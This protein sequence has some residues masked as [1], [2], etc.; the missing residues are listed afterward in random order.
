MV[1][2]IKPDEIKTAEEGK[3]IITKEAFRNMLTHVLR[4][5]NEALESSAEVMGICM[6]KANKKDLIIVNAIPITHGSKVEVGFS[7]EDYIAFAQIDEQYASKGLFAV[8]WYH[9]HPGWGLFYSD[10]DIR[11][12]I[13]YQKD[14]TPYAFGIV[15]D[16]TLMGKD[17]GLGFDVYRLEDYKKGPQSNYV[18]VQY[19]LEIPSTLDYFKWVQ[20]FI[21]DSQ[22]KDPI[23]IKEL[24]EL[25]EPTKDNLQAIPIPDGV[26]PDAVDDY[27]AITPI[28]S[29]FQE[30]ATLFQESFSNMFKSQLGAW[31]N[32]VSNGASK[33]AELM[34]ETLGQMNEAIS[35]GMNK[36]QKWFE[37]NIDEIVDEFKTD[38]SEYLDARITAQKEL[39]SQ[40][41]KIK[42]DIT[43]ST[44][45]NVEEKVKK[46]IEDTNEKVKGTSELINGATETS[47]KV[48]DLISAS[49]KHV[50]KIANE[51]N[52]LSEVIVKGIESASAP[53]EEELTKEI[54][55][56][57]SE[58]SSVKENY[59]KIKENFEKLQK[60]IMDLR[61]I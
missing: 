12:H 13:F 52:A 48:E 25:A 51:V 23:L 36:V 10:T 49:S 61:N 37:T 40:I 43:S 1:E 57:S 3:V 35:F 17:G 47:A 22:K 8:G 4:F 18:K 27:P 44:T 45:S 39:A 21:E 30:G 56:L 9:S 32:D 53:I 46:I 60:T 38:V 50:V 58:L 6:G 34:R 54:E 55:K 11:N 28:I 19:D 42:D 14:Q 24:N 2:Q 16:H 33:G 59:S 26:L 7:Q 20:K 15:F 5:G 29:G 31:S 41:P